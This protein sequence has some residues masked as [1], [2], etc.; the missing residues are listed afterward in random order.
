MSYNLG[1]KIM[2]FPNQTYPTG[3]G[4]KKPRKL[5]QS[6]LFQGIR[7][8]GP[9]SRNACSSYL[10]F[11][12]AGGG[13]VGIFSGLLSKQSNYQTSISWG[14][15]LAVGS[16][17]TF[18]REKWFYKR[19]P[20]VVQHGNGRSTFYILSHTCRYNMYTYIYIQSCPK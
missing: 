9:I 8:N 5:G 11:F 16:R 13:G 20:L 15:K 14:G 2:D 10:Y 17:C 6:H 19:Y 4:G 1:R 12:L 7:L 3:I 18:T